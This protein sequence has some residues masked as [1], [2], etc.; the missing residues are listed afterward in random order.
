[1]DG[2]LAGGVLRCNDPAC[3][4][5]VRGSGIEA[6]DRASRPLPAPSLASVW[7]ALAALRACVVPGAHGPAAFRA[8]RALSRDSASMRMSQ[9]PQIHR[10]RFSAFGLPSA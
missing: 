5:A 3:A 2:D 1:M 9:A 8:S 7:R 4:V 6:H 10:D